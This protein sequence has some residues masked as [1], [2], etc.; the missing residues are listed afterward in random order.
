MLQSTVDTL[1]KARGIVVRNDGI[2]KYKADVV[3]EL[4]KVIISASLMIMQ[5]KVKK[6]KI[7]KVKVVTEF[8]ENIRLPIIKLEFA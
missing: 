8:D 2:F 7:E 3:K 5:L 4:S 1:K 6:E